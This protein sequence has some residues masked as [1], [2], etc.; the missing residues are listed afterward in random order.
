MSTRSTQKATFRGSMTAMVTPFRNGEVDWPRVQSLVERQ[1]AGGT[2]WL[3]PCGTTGES[4]TISDS[5]WI[6]IVETTV[7]TA[8]GRVPVMAGTG[9]NDTAHAIELTKRAASFGASAALV[10]TP[11]YNRPPQE[12]LF[13]HYAAIAE[14]CDLPI[15]LY[16]VP[17]RTGVSMH[18]D[19]V[20][21]LRER[22]PHISAIKHATGSVEG[23]TDLRNRCDIA[24]ISGDDS[25]TWP[26]M[27]LGCAG[28]ISVL[29]NLL[30]ELLRSLVSKAAD[31]AI[32]E[33]L[34]LHR[35]VHDLAEGLARFGPNPMPIKTAMSLAGLIEPEFRLPLCPLDE[36]ART[37]IAQLLRRHEVPMA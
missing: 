36:Q 30:P 18:N 33:V 11:Y 10:V 3:V 7:H 9:S 32:A 4:P 26:L 34:A 21:R 31:G 14:S 16:N 22:F 25:I 27:S 20:V 37:G 35:R 15:V 13:R 19:T 23:V 29:S 24:I 1:I 17:I 2:D 5:E 6:R 8:R 28:V 12:G